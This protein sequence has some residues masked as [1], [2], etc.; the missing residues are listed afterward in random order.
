MSDKITLETFPNSVNAAVAYAWLR[1]QD[2]SALTPEEAIDKYE[3][4]YKRIREHKK[5]KRKAVD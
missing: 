3:D 5:Q 1:G 4:A 2:L